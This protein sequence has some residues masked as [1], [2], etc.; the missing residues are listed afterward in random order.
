MDSDKTVDE[1]LSKKYCT[2]SHVTPACFAVLIQIAIH[3]N[4]SD[5]GN[6][7]VT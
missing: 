1:N 4:A 2:F 5:R 3:I 7:P 6:F